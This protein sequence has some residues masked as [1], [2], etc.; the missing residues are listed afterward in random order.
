MKITRATDIVY[1]A[2]PPLEIQASNVQPVIPAHRYA[3]RL[4]ALRAKMAERNLDS[5]LVYADREHFWNFKYFLGYDPRFEEALLV[6]NREDPSYVIMGNECLN[7]HVLSPI[8]VEPLL[9]QEFSLPNQP[10]DKY[11]PLEDLIRRA[12]VVSG[13]RAGV[14]DWKMFTDAAGNVRRQ[15]F[16]V[17]SFILNGVLRATGENGSV[18]NATD[19]LIHSGYGLRIRHDADTIALMEYGASIASDAVRRQMEKLQPGVREGELVN[20]FNT[21]G[22]Q[23]NLHP[24]A[25]AG[26]NAH[27]GLVCSSDYE[28]RLGDGLNLCIALEGGLSCRHGYVAKGPEDLKEEYRDY[29]EKLVKPYYAAVVSWYENMRIG[30][31]GKEIYNM[32]QEIFPK[33]EYGWTLNPGHLGSNEEW[34]SSPFYPGSENEICSGMILQMDI[35]PQ[36]GRYNGPNTED[37]I[38]IADAQLRRELEENYPDVY[39]RMQLRRDYMINVIGIQLPEEVL[40]MS[41]LAGAFRPYMMNLDMGMKVAGK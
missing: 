35:I 41:N 28:I 14:I 15:V 22:L 18:E 2:L 7:L 40:P 29:V 25:L 8:K 36:V 26:E 4:S 20:E 10:M 9:C 38:C 3:A 37:G 32:I 27:K 19:M 16:A 11:V 6:I 39:A 5:V 24:F 33:E 30:T 21:F 12:G 31:R 1:G 13:A 23:H 34:Q 17:P